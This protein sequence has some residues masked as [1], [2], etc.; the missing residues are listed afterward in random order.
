MFFHIPIKDKVK[1]RQDK[2][3]S[4]KKYVIHKPPSNTEYIIIN[5]ETKV[6]EIAK[7]IAVKTQQLFLI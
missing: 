1:D 2:N 4:C 3:C 7:K 6:N 5:I